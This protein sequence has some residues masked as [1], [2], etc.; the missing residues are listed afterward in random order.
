MAHK[1]VSLIA[2]KKALAAKKAKDKKK[3]DKKKKLT[4]LA[5]TMSTGKKDRG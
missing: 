5:T 1:K 2:K 4:L 3:A